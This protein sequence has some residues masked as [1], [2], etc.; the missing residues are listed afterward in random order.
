MPQADVLPIDQVL[1]LLTILI[2]QLNFKNAVVVVPG[3]KLVANLLVNRWVDVVD[4][5]LCRP[6]VREPKVSTAFDMQC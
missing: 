6:N 3:R 5:E 4:F 1:P 2:P